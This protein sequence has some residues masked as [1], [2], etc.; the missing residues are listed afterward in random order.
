M[1]A[2]EPFAVRDQE[3]LGKSSAEAAQRTELGEG[4]AARRTVPRSQPVGDQ[5]FRWRAAVG[6]QVGSGFLCRRATSVRG[7]R[8]LRKR[9]FIFSTS[10]HL[11]A[12]PPAAGRRYGAAPPEPGTGRAEHGKPNPLAPGP[13]PSRALPAPRPGLSRRP[14]GRRPDRERRASGGSAGR[15][16]GWGAARRGPFKARSG[17]AGRPCGGAPCLVVLRAHWPAPP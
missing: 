7:G 9:F 6:L 4:S 1:G 16:G 15:G 13:P 3:R 2:L 12:N 5:R 17:G 14:P 11:G 8:A 10:G